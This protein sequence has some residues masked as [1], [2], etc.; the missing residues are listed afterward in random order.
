MDSY[1]QK[2]VSDPANGPP[3]YDYD[4]PTSNESSNYDAPNYD[5][6]TPTSYESPDS[7][8]LEVYSTVNS[9][10]D[11]IDLIGDYVDSDDLD[12]YG[13]GKYFRM[14]IRSS[15]GYFLFERFYQ[16]CIHCRLN[17]I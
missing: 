16:I 6:E 4:S 11:I 7:N 2:P 13:A 17:Y 15:T 12:S 3:N 1:L 10:E 8:S 9:S 14:I 5:Y